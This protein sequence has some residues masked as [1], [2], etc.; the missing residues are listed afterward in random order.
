MCNIYEYRPKIRVTLFLADLTMQSLV[1]VIC[2]VSLPSL[3]EAAART[4]RKE[5]N[6]HTDK[7]RRIDV[8]K[9]VVSNAAES[10]HARKA[11]AIMK[12]TFGYGRDITILR[13]LSEKRRVG[14]KATHMPSS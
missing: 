9:S 14:L 8:R 13:H 11:N 4:D 10:V 6:A 3:F 7:T 12:V 5:K 2:Y 1:V